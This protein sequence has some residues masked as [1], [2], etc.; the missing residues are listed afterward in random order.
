[1]FRSVN[2]F[3]PF[4][5]Q[6]MFVEHN[7]GGY[8]LVKKVGQKKISTKMGKTDTIE[9]TLTD[10][11]QKEYTII[12]A[13][14][15]YQNFENLLHN[16]IS[17]EKT[18]FQ[19]LLNLNAI[20]LSTLVDKNSPFVSQSQTL[21]HRIDEDFPIEFIYH[22]NNIEGSK[23]PKDEIRNILQEKKVTY[24]VKNEIQEVK[25]SINSRTFLQKNFLRNISNIK[26][27]Y[28]ILTKN[29]L[30]ENG[31]PYPRGFKKIP[32]VVNNETTVDPKQVEQ[33]I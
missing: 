8:F 19:S 26:K 7:S 30:Q 24:K 33:E 27:L 23:I 25:N 17:L 13:S 6:D 18:V 3:Y 9:K 12:I 31:N 22:S 11:T 10:I 32:I 20:E 2:F 15:E 5:I 16:K 14:A 4:I 29:L 1:M 28:H 21:Q